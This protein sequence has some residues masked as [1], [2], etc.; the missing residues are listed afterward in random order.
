[1][2][3]LG[4]I[5]ILQSYG[6]KKQAE[7]PSPLSKALPVQQGLVS[8]HAGGARGQ[9]LA[10]TNIAVLR[11]ALAKS[12]IWDQ[13][14]VSV[15]PPNFY[16]RRFRFYM[17]EHVFH[18]DDTVLERVDLLQSAEPQSA[19][20]ICVHLQAVNA[21]Q[22]RAARERFVPARPPQCS[23]FDR[24][25]R[26]GTD[27]AVHSDEGSDSD[28]D[29]RTPSVGA[30]SEATRTP[31]PQEQKR[32]E[33]WIQHHK[34]MLQTQSMLSTSRAPQFG[35]VAHR[36][37]TLQSGTPAGEDIPRLHRRRPVQYHAL[38]ASTAQHSTHQ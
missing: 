37:K 33:I 26:A 20:R 17:N 23:E 2:V 29:T 9:C 5:D 28:E 27:G 25:A 1:M 24:H 32:R 31:D 35:S 38:F 18:P 8:V 12:M 15:S 11:A 6:G 19:N 4:I 21:A 22:K 7:G 16:G 34:R 36:T 14:A 30:G 3:H 13:A 10:S